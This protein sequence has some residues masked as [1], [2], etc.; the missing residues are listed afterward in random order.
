MLL[1][2]VE[3]GV[4]GHLNVYVNPQNDHLYEKTATEHYF[5]DEK[6]L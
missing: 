5:W 6:L 2:I 4:L 1:N 3:K